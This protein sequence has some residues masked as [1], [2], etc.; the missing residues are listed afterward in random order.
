MSNIALSQ[1]LL[2]N[3]DSKFWEGIFIKYDFE[4][5]FSFDEYLGCTSQ[6]GLC[7]R[8]YK[9]FVEYF[10]NCRHFSTLF[11][12]NF[13]GFAC[14]R[15]QIHPSFSNNFNLLLVFLDESSFFIFDSVLDMAYIFICLIFGVHFLT[16]FQIPA[17]TS[18][19]FRSG[20][21]RSSYLG[22]SD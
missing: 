15:F 21:R 14:C 4:R 20:N 7:I 2:P 12:D 19:N 22:C 3:M 18:T 13:H 6:S 5:I 16:F 9:L 1:L 11:R 17:G 10:S 8:C